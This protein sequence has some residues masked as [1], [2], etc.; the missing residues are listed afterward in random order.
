MPLASK[1][2]SKLAKRESLKVSANHSDLELL[3]CINLNSASGIVVMLLV[4]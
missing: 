4:I 3:V 1:E 2:L